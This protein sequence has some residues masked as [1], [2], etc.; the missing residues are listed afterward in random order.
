[1]THYQSKHS[2]NDMPNELKITKDE[3]KKVFVFKLFRRSY[4]IIFI[5]NLIIIYDTIF[6]QVSV[7]SLA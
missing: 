4:R 3:K 7:K 2:L 5:S 1:M 6:L